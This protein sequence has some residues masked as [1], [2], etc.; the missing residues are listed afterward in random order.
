[1][2]RLETSILQTKKHKHRKMDVKP[3]TQEELL[4]RAE[5]SNNDYLLGNVN[6]QEELGKHSESW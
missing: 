5:Q 6:T 1:M 4:K 3:F 2:K